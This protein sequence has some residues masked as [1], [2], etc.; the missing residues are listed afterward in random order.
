MKKRVASRVQLEGPA[1]T[2]FAML[3]DPSRQQLAKKIVENYEAVRSVL[4]YERRVNPQ[5]K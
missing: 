3:K 2:Q 4:P 1:E 5:G